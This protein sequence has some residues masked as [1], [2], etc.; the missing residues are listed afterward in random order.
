MGC[1]AIE[2]VFE[3]IQGTD[4][5]S[6]L[7]KC[8]KITQFIWWFQKLLLTSRKLNALKYERAEFLL[9]ISAPFGYCRLC[10]FRL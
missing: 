2:E 6:K 4:K 1:K 10:D 5:E 3:G 7:N 8:V 9:Q